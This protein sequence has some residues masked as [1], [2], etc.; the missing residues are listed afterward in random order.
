M[1]PYEG[2]FIE[3]LQ[4]RDGAKGIQGLI[5]RLGSHVE[6]DALLLRDCSLCE[7]ELCEDSE[8]KADQQRTAQ[9]NAPALRGILR[10]LRQ[11]TSS[12]S[13]DCHAPRR[14]TLSGFCYTQM[15][16]EEL[17][18]GGMKGEARTAR[19]KQSSLIIPPA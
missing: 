5:E 13:R 7:A 11:L 17:R 19:A 4:A 18:V 1:M 10:I 2:G 6:I 16:A 15:P 9:P 3:N 14:V 12:C 8:A